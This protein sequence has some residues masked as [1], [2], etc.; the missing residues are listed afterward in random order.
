MPP[1]NAARVRASLAILGLL[2]SPLAGAGADG[3]ADALPAIDAPAM[4]NA[5]RRDTPHE[6]FAA[7]EKTP[8]A[9]R[10]A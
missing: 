5:P 1:R 8:L 7:S 10:L 6:S 3:V 9:S 2:M 4:R